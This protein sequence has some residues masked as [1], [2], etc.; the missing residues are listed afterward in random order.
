MILTW[1]VVVLRYSPSSEAP[2]GQLGVTRTSRA[3][4]ILLWGQTFG[5]NNGCLVRP[6]APLQAQ[7]KKDIALKEDI[8]VRYGSRPGTTHQLSLR[9]KSSHDIHH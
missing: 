4:E 7:T 2:G 8:G 6:W 9:T 1:E 3:S 5:T